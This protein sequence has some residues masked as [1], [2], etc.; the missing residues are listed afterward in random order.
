MSIGTAFSAFFGILFNKEKAEL[1][2]KAN[3]GSVTQDTD[4]FKDEAEKEAKRIL[5]DAYLETAEAK[6]NSAESV[7]KSVPRTVSRFDNGIFS[8]IAKRPKF[9]PKEC[10]N[11]ISCVV[12]EKKGASPAKLCLAN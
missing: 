11:L 6:K 4:K 3:S 8:V 1:W 2:N 5:D 12:E 9:R 10:D 7:P